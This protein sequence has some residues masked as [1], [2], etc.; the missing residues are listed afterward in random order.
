MLHRY[1]TAIAQGARSPQTLAAFDATRKR[2]R[3]EQEQIDLEDWI[4]EQLYSLNRAT[5]A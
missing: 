2:E 1:P 5:F 4:A 3:E